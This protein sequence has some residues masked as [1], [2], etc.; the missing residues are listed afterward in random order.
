MGYIL[1]SPRAAACACD[2][3]HRIRDLSSRGSRDVFSRCAADVFNAGAD[4]VSLGAESSGVL[5]SLVRIAITRRRVVHRVRVPVRMRRIAPRVRHAHLHRRA[6]R[7]DLLLLADF[8]LPFPVVIPSHLSHFALRVVHQRR[9]QNVFTSHAAYARFH[10]CMGTGEHLR[11]ALGHRSND[12]HL[13]RRGIAEDVAARMAGR[14]GTEHVACRS[15]GDVMGAV[16]GRAQSAVQLVLSLGAR[17]HAHRSDAP[18]PAVVE[19]LAMVRR[20]C[21][22]IVSH[23]YRRADE[24]LVVHRVNSLLH[25]VLAAGRGV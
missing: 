7:F 17:H 19:D 18:V 1:V 5:P 24:H 9:G 10:V 23:R 4:V 11:A 14:C 2:R 25:F 20:T 16:G 15:L 21:R 3:A 8:L 12:V 22:R 13:C 6:H